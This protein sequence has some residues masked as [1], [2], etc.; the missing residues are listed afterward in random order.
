MLSWSAE[1]H[2]R[3]RVPVVTTDTRRSTPAAS[4]KIA[5]HSCAR[6]HVCLSAGCDLD[7]STEMD[8]GSSPTPVCAARTP[9]ARPCVWSSVPCWSTGD[10][11][12]PHLQHRAWKRNRPAITR[13]HRAEGQW[14]LGSGVPPNLVVRGVGNECVRAVT[15]FLHRL[16]PERLPIR[17]GFCFCIGLFPRA[18]A[19]EIR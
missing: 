13:M 5:T 6:D 18:H 10:A 9:P 14:M 15:H 1:K 7:G 19:L 3:P 12:Y 17:M 8:H 2:S 11:A 4:L 16:R